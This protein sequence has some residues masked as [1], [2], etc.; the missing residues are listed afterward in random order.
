MFY[1]NYKTISQT[2]EE[3]LDVSSFF[4]INRDNNNNIKFSL[5]L[6]FLVYKKLQMLYLI[7]NIHIYENMIKKKNI[8]FLKYL[9]N[10]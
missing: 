10:W 6:S 9:W 7:L 4:R 8:C 5:V 3:L 1:V 2:N